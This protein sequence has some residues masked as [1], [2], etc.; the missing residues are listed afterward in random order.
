[1]HLISEENRPFICYHSVVMYEAQLQGSHSIQAGQALVINRMWNPSWETHYH[2][3]PTDPSDA[4]SF[5]QTHETI[6]NPSPVLLA[7]EQVESV[8]R[9]EE[10]VII[11]DFN[12]THPVG[13][14]ITS[15]LMEWKQ[16][17]EIKNCFLTTRNESWIP[18]CTA[19]A[20]TSSKLPSMDL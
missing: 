11:Q 13:I 14:E 7:D 15:N 20:V 3:I 6:L 9:S 8:L 19:A 12:S 4:Q 17:E 1:M 5:L 16:R 18:E 10:V 2:W